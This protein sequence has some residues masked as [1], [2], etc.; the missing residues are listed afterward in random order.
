MGTTS[1]VVGTTWIEVASGV[2]KIFVQRRS[3]VAVRFHVGTTVPDDDTDNYLMLKTT[4]M[5][6]ADI[7]EGERVFLRSDGNA[8]EVAVFAGSSH[9][10]FF[11]NRLR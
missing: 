9:V 3:S 2:E 8:T 5:S 6:I 7:L 1:Y 10:Q 11:D 4:E